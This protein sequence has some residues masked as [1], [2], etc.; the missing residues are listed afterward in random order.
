MLFNPRGLRSAETVVDEH[1][2]GR[3]RSREATAE[4]LESRLD[5][6]NS[7]QVAVLHQT[8]AFQD[9]IEEI[10]ERARPKEEPRDGCTVARA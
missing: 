4:G 3:R 8:A 9:E 6:M 1:R 7:H 10:Q 2:T 5:G